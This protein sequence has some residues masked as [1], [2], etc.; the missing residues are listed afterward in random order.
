MKVDRTG[1]EETRHGSGKGKL[2]NEL[3][4]VPPIQLDSDF[5]RF[6]LDSKAVQMDSNRNSGGLIAD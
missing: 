5:A 4:H 2:Q 6:N 1:I 3:G